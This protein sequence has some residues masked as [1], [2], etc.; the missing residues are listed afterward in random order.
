MQTQEVISVVP[1][2][3]LSTHPSWS[4]GRDKG[5]NSYEFQTENHHLLLVTP[6]QQQSYFHQLLKFHHLLAKSF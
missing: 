5:K 1:H 2:L 4:R 6:P 3:N